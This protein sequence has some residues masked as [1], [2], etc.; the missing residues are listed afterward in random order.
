MCRG[1]VTPHVTGMGVAL[2]SKPEYLISFIYS[3]IVPKYTLIT[4]LTF[5]LL[6][7]LKGK[8]RYF[9]MHEY[10]LLTERA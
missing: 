3:F 8:L 9:L 4:N 1:Y 7:R 10:E 2:A 5:R 6:F